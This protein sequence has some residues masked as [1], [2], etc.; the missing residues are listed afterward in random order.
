M[1]TEMNYSAKLMQ[2]IVLFHKGFCLMI[3]TISVV[4]CRLYNIMKC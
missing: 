1:Y 4:S 3:R 2:N